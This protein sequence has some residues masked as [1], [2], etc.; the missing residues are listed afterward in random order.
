MTS[1]RMLISGASGL[2]GTALVPTLEARGFSVTRLV[3]RR[4]SG[5]ND[6][7]WDPTKPLSPE[8]VSGFDAVIHLAGEP[9][10]GLWT[11]AKRARIRDSRVLSTAHLSEALAKTQQRPRVF[12]SGSATGYYG[13][14][15]DEVMREDSPSGEGFL[16]EV[17]RKWEA[18][19]KP[20]EDA[21][22]RTV[23]IRTGIVLSV[24]GG[25]LRAMLPNFKLE[26]GG[27]IGSGRQWMSWIHMQ[28]HIGAICY[29]IDHEL[30]QGPVN[31]VGPTPVKN[32]EFTET[33]ARVLSR[34]AVLGVPAFALRLILGD[35]AKEI[36]LASQ[37]VEPAKLIESGFK[38]KYQDLQSA[39]RNILR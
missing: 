9:V 24:E 23:H 17:C 29:I 25:A 27:K 21:G 16:P 1:S 20:A 36:L 12:I 7:E 30:I 32:S 4:G 26:L 38:F 15:G 39:L 35:M 22:I 2:I 19:T 8:L 10:M 28:D 31:L 34:P 3:R 14:R 33:L 11:D 6:I 37:R 5:N 13:D 18:A